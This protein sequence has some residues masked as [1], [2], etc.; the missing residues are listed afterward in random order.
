MWEPQH[1][2]TLWASTA[3]YRDTFTPLTQSK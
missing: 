2:I 1:L 3:G